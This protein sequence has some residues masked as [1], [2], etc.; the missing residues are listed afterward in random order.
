MEIV[1]YRAQKSEKAH[2]AWRPVT[3]DQARHMIKY[4]IGAEDERDASVPDYIKRNIYTPGL[5]KNLFDLSSLIKYAGENHT[6]PFWVSMSL[7]KNVKGQGKGRPIRTFMLDLTPYRAI[8]KVLHPVKLEAAIHS[9]RPH[10]LLDTPHLAVANKIVLLHAQSGGECEVSY[11]SP[12]PPGLVLKPLTPDEGNHPTSTSK[13]KPPVPD[14]SNRP[15][16]PTTKRKPS[17]PD[18]SNRPKRPR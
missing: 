4:L 17:I 13:S 7:D 15:P 2:G 12:L 8:G 10:L 1:F 5:R 14:K 3:H 16:R 9:I 6:D 18:K 11:I